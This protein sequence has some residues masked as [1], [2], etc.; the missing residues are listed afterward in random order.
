MASPFRLPILYLILGV[1]ILVSVVPLYFYATQVVG[2]NRDQLKT[3]EQVLQNTITGSLAEDITQRQAN[4]RT[5]L[6]NL[7]SAIQ[8]ASGS[9][10]TGEHVSSPE[11]RALLE[12]FVSSS[13]DIAYATILND[14]MKGPRASRIALIVASVPDVVRRTRS[15]DGNASTIKRASPIS[16][17]W[18]AP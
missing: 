5:M 18:H 12:K 13:P 1:L 7:S 14:E 6:A 17:G 15:I 9:N 2:I 11:L 10:L 4:L 16:Y 3:Q 8:V